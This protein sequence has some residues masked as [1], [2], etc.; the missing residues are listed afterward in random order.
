MYKLLPAFPPATGTRDDAILR[1][2][3]TA[4]IPTD[5]DNTD[6]QQYLKWVEEG[7]TPLPADEGAA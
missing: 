1:V 4:Y 6:Y 7:N 2:A 5:P 3:D